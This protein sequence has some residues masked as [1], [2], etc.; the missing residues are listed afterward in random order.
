[1]RFQTGI[2]S[3]YR[4]TRGAT[5]EIKVDKIMKSFATEKKKNLT[6][7][8]EEENYEEGRLVRDI[9]WRNHVPTKRHHRDLEYSATESLVLSKE[10]KRQDWIYQE[11]SHEWYD[12][13]LVRQFRPNLVSLRSVYRV[14][15]VN[16]ELCGECG[17][18][19]DLGLWAAQNYM[20][21][22]YVPQW[23]MRENTYS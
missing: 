12:H 1:M 17:I 20:P 6:V 18:K 7:K 13:Y 8:C 10:N 11:P 4:A 16:H 3:V 22:L 14:E 9:R 23:R 19:D 2:K 21:L 15:K 5:S